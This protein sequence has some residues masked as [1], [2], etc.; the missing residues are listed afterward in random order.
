MTKQIME[1]SGVL[2][3]VELAKL[4]IDQSYQRP[5]MG[6]VRKMVK[7]FDPRACEPLTVGRRADKSLWVIDGQQRREAL[8]KLGFAHWRALVLESTGPAFE[9]DLFQTLG[10]GKGTVKQLRTT[11]VFKAQVQS[12]DPVALAMKQTA[13]KWGFD[14]P[15][16]AGRPYPFIQGIKGVYRHVQSHGTKFLDLALETISRSWPSDPHSVGY[17]VVMGVIAFWRMFPASDKERL[18]RQ[19]QKVNL[20]ALT[21]AVKQSGGLSMQASGSMVVTREL[22][23]RYNSKLAPKNRLKIVMRSLGDYEGDVGVGDEGGSEEVA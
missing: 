1:S 3:T 8:M 18:I 16:C 12:G 10:G 5:L 6:H 15:V 13:K 19:L 14:F 4:N 2:E 20:L 23:N 7:D 17:A 22:V 9:A 21:Q 11:D